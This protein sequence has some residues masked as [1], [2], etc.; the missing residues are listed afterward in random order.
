MITKLIRPELL[1]FKS[2]KTSSTTDDVSKKTGI[3]VDKI[4]K[5]DAG[6][7]PYVEYLQ[8]RHFFLQQ[9]LYSY[10]DSTCKKLREKLTGYTGFPSDWI[11]CGNGSDEL[12]DL[13][14]RTFI[15]VKDEIIISPPTFS[16]YQFYGQLAGAKI[17]PVLRNEKMNI[18]LKNLQKAVNSKTKIIFIDSPG[19]PGGRVESEVTIRK[20]LIQNVLVVVDE[21]YFEYSGQSVL[22]LVKEYSNLAVLRSFSKWAGLAGLRIGYLIANPR[23]IEIISSIK[24]PYSVNS[25]AQLMAC[26][27]LDKR[28][29]FLQEIKKIILYRDKFIK[30]LSK[31]KSLKVYPSD[32]AYVV[33]QPSSKSMQLVQFLKG[34]GILVK[35]I[36]QPLMENCIRVN[37]GK[38]EELDKLIFQLGRFY[39]EKI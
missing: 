24:S 4:L 10:P 15:C 20:L 37:L 14:I 30:K 39:E 31:I 18:N 17:N 34:K 28:V 38:K 12:I 21:A 27:V 6:E 9:K 1:T 13:L 16:M 19:N 32:G 35:E 7:N 5:L 8:A 33:F 25:V 36:N 26:A 23:I 22:P 11:L 29:E 2:Y 3:P